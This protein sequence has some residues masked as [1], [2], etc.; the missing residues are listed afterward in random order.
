MSR[1]PTWG[2]GELAATIAR[3]SK[4]REAADTAAVRHGWIL[5]ERVVGALVGTEPRLVL[6]AL[7]TATPLALAAAMVIELSIR[8][9]SMV[10]LPSVAL[11]RSN[12]AGGRASSV[13][14][15]HEPL[16][17]ATLEHPVQASLGSRTAVEPVVQ[18]AIFPKRVLLQI[19][20]ELIDL[21]LAQGV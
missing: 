2:S 14:R 20:D 6:R 7:L 18:S 4:T 12:P 17:R 16:T 8:P 11:P 10:I 19:D 9:R 5:Q 3:H 13:I 21:R 15:C 1:F